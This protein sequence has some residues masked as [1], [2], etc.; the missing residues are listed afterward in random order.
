MVYLIYVQPFR[1]YLLVQT[2]NQTQCDYI[3]H[4]PKGPW[5]TDHLTRVIQRETGI[6]LGHRFHTLDFRHIV[7]SIGRVVVNERFAAGYKEELGEIEEPD[8]DL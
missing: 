4:G 6:G 7:I 1:E 5:E 3:W 2:Q 8:A